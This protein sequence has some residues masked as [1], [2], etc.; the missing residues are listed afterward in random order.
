MY[1]AGVSAARRRTRDSAGWMRWRRASK[2]SPRPSRSATTI[3]PS[4]TQR[5]GQRLPQRVEELGEVAG[6]R[7][8]VAAGQLDVVA[9]AEHDA[10]EA[11][12]LRLEQPAVAVGDGPGQLGEH[13]LERRGEREDHDRILARRGNRGAPRH[14]EGAGTSVG[15][16]TA[17]T[18]GAA[19]TS[20]WKIALASAAGAAVAAVAVIALSGGGVRRRRRHRARR[21][22]ARRPRPTTASAALDHRHRAR[23]GGGRARHRHRLDRRAGQR[24]HGRRGDGHDRHEVAGARRHA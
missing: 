13:R 19:M 10:A 14:V 4:T 5:A 23:H 7:A 2:S 16:P 9:V 12:P 20:R 8:L 1:D 22:R 18:Q 3:S 17:R 11:V 21:L 24:R 6:E 15:P